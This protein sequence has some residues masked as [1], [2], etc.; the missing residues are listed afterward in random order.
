MKHYRIG[1]LAQKCQIHKETIRYYER[2]GLFQKQSGQKAGIVCIR[3][4]RSGESGLLNSCKGS[5]S[6]W[7]KLINCLALSIGIAIDAKTC[8]ALL[9]K[10]SRRFKPAFAI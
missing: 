2:K 10:R 8:T 9:R 4:R 5:D 6:P 3:R 7:R 1:E